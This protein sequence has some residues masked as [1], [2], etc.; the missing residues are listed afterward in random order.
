MHPAAALSL[1]LALF[2]VGVQAGMPSMPPM[3]NS[4]PR[5]VVG[6]APGLA[7]A[8]TRP[9]YRANMGRV[10]GQMRRNAGS[11]AAVT[12]GTGLI[13]GATAAG[14]AIEV[15]RYKNVKEST[16]LMQAVREKTQAEGHVE[17]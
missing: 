1:L 10:G 14:V 16:K 15:N 12:V 2:S 6:G 9:T 4:M 11:I 8:A 17:E 3:A 13:V 5:S 7:G